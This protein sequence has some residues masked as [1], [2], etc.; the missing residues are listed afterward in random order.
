MAARCRER[1]ATDPSPLTATVE[2][3]LPAPQTTVDAE[4]V[5]TALPQETVEAPAT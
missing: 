1:F 4:D 2:P 5:G 3:S